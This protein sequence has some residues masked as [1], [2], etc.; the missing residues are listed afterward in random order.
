MARANIFSKRPAGRTWPGPDGAGAN[1]HVQFLPG[2]LRASAQTGAKG[3]LRFDMELVAAAGQDFTAAHLQFHLRRD[4]NGHDLDLMT[5]ADDVKG[6]PLTDWRV[7]ASLSNEAALMPLLAG[8]ASWPQTVMAW[9]AVGGMAKYDVRQIAPTV[10]KAALL[11]DPPTSPCL[12]RNWVRHCPGRSMIALRMARV[13]V[14]KSNRNW[15][16][17]ARSAFSGPPGRH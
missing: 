8:N 1:H 3:L 7:Y 13:R 4:P 5:S 17:P 9:H 15:P 2:S 10:S 6:A 12:Y 11:F 16:S 14:K